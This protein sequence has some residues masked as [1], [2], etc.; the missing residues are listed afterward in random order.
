MLRFGNSKLFTELK[1]ST[2]ASIT[3]CKNGNQAADKPL[4]ISKTACICLDVCKIGKQEA[5]RGVVVS[6]FAHAGALALLGVL[7]QSCHAVLLGSKLYLFARGEAYCCTS[8][9]IH[10]HKRAAATHATVG[11]GHV[12][13]FV[14]VNEFVCVIV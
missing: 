10:A 14:Q 1:P 11:I 2:M 7:S 5:D 6:D 4:S 12:H 3:A 8:P 13:L 9:Y